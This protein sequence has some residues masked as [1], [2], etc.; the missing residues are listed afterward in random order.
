MKVVIVC[1]NQK[2]GAAAGKELAQNLNMTFADC[3]EEIEA[4]LAR[5]GAMLKQI[6]AEWL[7]RHERQVVAQ[8][9]KSD[10]V[11]FDYNIF[12]RHRH[13]VTG[14]IIYLKLEKPQVDKI[15]SSRFALLD[16][17]L[18]GLAKF[19]IKS[20]DATFAA[21]EIAKIIGEKK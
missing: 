19:V 18:S 6:T 1:L 12:S 8:C 5:C 9:L 10:I 16:L 7:D 17:R 15:Y 13:R 20:R 2:F 14:D 4:S 3:A 11:N 21:E